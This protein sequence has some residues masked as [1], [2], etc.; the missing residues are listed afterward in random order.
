MIAAYAILALPP[1]NNPVA[2]FG[3]G[4]A[5]G[6]MTGAPSFLAGGFLFIVGF[7]EIFGVGMGD[8]SSCMVFLFASGDGTALAAGDGDGEGFFDGLGAG[9]LKLPPLEEEL[10]GW[11][12]G[13]GVAYA[14]T[15]GDGLGEGVGDGDGLGLID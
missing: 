11:A 3:A 6:E 15:E 7:T 8:G 14:M 4:G 10:D 9:G 13:V 12:V 1:A 2:G 5:L